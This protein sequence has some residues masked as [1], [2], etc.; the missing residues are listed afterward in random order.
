MAGPSTVWAGSKEIEGGAGIFLTDAVKK[1]SDTQAR[2]LYT[3]EL[4]HVLGLGHAADAGNIMSP[5]GRRALRAR[6]RRHRR[7]PDDDQAVRGIGNET[8]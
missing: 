4:G 1:M 7:R 3:H 6:R 5:V 2:A 8:F